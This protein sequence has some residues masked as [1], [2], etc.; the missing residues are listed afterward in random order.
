MSETNPPASST[1]LVCLNWPHVGFDEQKI[2]TQW[3][4][5]QYRHLC[6]RGAI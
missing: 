1:I 4:A 3:L 5:D 6:L 2:L